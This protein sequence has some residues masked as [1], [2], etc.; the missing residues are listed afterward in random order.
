MVHALSWLAADQFLHP[1]Q[2]AAHAAA[3]GPDQPLITDVF[4]EHGY[5]TAYFGK[6]HLGGYNHITTIPRE[7]RGRFDIWI[8]YENNNAQYDC[9]VHGHDLDGRDDQDATA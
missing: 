2:R 7:E 4:N 8:G 1:S 6:W 9:W 5:L 3:D